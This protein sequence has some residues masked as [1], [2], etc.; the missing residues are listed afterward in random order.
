MEG[1]DGVVSRGI[2]PLEDLRLSSYAEMALVVGGAGSPGRD[3]PE[4]TRA[5]ADCLDLLRA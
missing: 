4:S 1:A 3:S 2:P 5:L